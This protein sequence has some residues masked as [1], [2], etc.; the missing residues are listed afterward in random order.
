MD[1][2]MLSLKLAHV[3]VV[4]SHGVRNWRVTRGGEQAHRDNCGEESHL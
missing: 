1:L 4:G 3:A 2:I